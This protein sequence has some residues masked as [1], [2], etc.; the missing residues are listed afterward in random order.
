MDIPSSRLKGQRKEDAREY[1]RAVV[2]PLRFS[3]K[4][5]TKLYGA[6]VFKKFNTDLRWVLN[7][8]HF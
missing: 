2:R 4:E 8:V 5:N 7:S 6:N 3:Y 1:Y